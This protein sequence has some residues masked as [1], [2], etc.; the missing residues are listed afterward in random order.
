MTV[1]F[2]FCIYSKSFIIIHLITF[3]SSYRINNSIYYVKWH[4]NKFLQTFQYQGM[5]IDD[6]LVVYFISFCLSFL[7]FPLNL[8]FFYFKGNPIVCSCNIAWLVTN[9]E[10]LAKVSGTCVDGDTISELNPGD[11]SDC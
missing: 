11:F 6:V 8:I 10:Y 4:I 3:N 1:K 2:C 9:A 5:C 7:F